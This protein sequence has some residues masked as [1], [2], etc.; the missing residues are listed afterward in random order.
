MLRVSGPRTERVLT[1]QAY[2]ASGTLLWQ[3]RIAAS[4]L[5]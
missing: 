4:E 5:R 1:L 2:D 3:R